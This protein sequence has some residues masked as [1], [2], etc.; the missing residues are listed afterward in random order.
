[1][2]VHP[3]SLNVMEAGEVVDHNSKRKLNRRAH[4]SPPGAASLALRAEHTPDGTVERQVELD[5]AATEA[6][7]PIERSSPAGKPAL[8]SHMALLAAET[9]L[10]RHPPHQTILREQPPASPD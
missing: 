5:M 9:H 8:V 3:F 6:A 1:M 7:A 4:K 2:E 10:L